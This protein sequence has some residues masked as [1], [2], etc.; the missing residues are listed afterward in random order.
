M[1]KKIV[2]L[3]LMTL[4]TLAI[5]FPVSACTG[6]TASD[7][8]NVL[9]GCNFDWSWDFN[10]YK[11]IF[12]AEDG[13]YGRIIFDIWWPYDDVDYTLAIQGM[14]DQ[15]LFVDT[16]MVPDHTVDYN[17]APFFESEDPDYY[18]DALWI[19]CL[20]KCS[21]INEVLDMY[22]QYDQEWE[23]DISYGQLFFVDKNGDS[24]IIEDCDSMI[25]KEG[26]FQVVTNYLQTQPELGGYPCW[27]YNT[28]CSMLENMTDLTVDFFT[29]ICNAT[30]SSTSVFSN[31]YDLKQEK[32]WIHYYYN[33]NNVLEI[34]L[35]D[36]LANGESRTYLGSFFEPDDNQQPNKPNTPTGNE[37]GFIGKE[38]EFSCDRTSDPDGD[39]ITY[40]FDWG[41][42]T[43]SNWLPKQMGM[44]VT[45]SHNWTDKGDFEVRVK[46]RDIY[47]YESEWSDP[48]IVSMP[49]SKEFNLF[50]QLIEKLFER[51]PMLELLFN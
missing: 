22:T 15:G 32:I 25:F 30:H 5:V 13:K 8:N 51:F 17:G 42:G 36:E 7:E 40:L 47:G 24:V 38:M 21:T 10:V 2:I 41:D 44:K 12:S 39:K 23:D 35:K 20:A 46:V 28:A 31:V 1:K 29:S 37:S 14:N 43:D 48:L 33:Y 27:R 45:A 19:Y 11:N 50:E 16:Y 4:L 34:D 9:V 18:G 3:I 49:K 26:N 6:F